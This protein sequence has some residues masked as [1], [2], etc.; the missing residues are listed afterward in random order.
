MWVEFDDAS[1]LA[2]MQ[3]VTYICRKA[4]GPFHFGDGMSMSSKDGFKPRERLGPA[5]SE[6]LDPASAV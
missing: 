5:V 1:A 3:C 2:C 4:A 6:G